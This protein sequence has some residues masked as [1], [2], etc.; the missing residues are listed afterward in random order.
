M[1]ENYNR[2]FDEIFQDVPVGSSTWDHWK[3]HDP[4]ILKVA[5]I[6]IQTYGANP[7]VF[8]A[9]ERHFDQFAT[10]ADRAALAAMSPL[11]RAALLDW[12]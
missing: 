5:A 10:E 7:W 6:T 1:S 8:A 2:I 9:D 3:K 11:M 4:A 12:D